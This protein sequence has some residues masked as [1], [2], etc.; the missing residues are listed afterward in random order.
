MI[1]PTDNAAWPDDVQVLY[2]HDTQ[3][4]W[5]PSLAPLVWN[6]YYNQLDA[7]LSLVGT[8]AAPGFWGVPHRFLETPFISG[9][10]KVRHLHGRVP[11]KLLRFADRLLLAMSGLVKKFSHQ[12]MITAQRPRLA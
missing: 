8:V 2:R 4:I 6:H 11:V 1:P 7:Y 12:M 9:H 10:M 3:E 5:D